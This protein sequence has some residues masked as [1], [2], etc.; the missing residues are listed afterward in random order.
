MPCPWFC[1]AKV[2]CETCEVVEIRGDDD[3]VEMD[4]AREQ[5]SVEDHR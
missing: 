3:V 1:L 2:R 4:C 5:V